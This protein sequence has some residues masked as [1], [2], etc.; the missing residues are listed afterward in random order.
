MQELLHTH[1][2]RDYGE[3]VSFWNHTIAF[4]LKI[5]DKVGI[6][7]KDTSKLSHHLVH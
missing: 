4:L 5:L 7:H 3:N 1:I 6:P 2:G